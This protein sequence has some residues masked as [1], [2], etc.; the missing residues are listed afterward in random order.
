[1]QTLV[2]SAELGQRLPT[3]GS[4]SPQLA[5]ARRPASGRR[6]TLPGKD[7]QRTGSCWSSAP[8]P[9]VISAPFAGRQPSAVGLGSA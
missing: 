2:L 9:T 1:M 8:L 3:A 6:N 7:R 4:A 5:G